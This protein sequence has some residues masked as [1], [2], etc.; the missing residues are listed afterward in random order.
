[1]DTGC[2]SET[3]FRMQ[4]SSWKKIILMI[5]FSELIS[6]SNCADHKQFLNIDLP[7]AYKTFIVTLSYIILKLI[8]IEL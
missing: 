3:I 2:Y 8:A 6:F 5:V 4:H 7:Q 1:M